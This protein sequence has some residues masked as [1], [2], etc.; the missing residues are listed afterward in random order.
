MPM[1]TESLIEIKDV[2]FNYGPQVILDHISLSV[3][4]GDFLGIIGPN[5]GGKSTLLK[6]ILGLLKPTSGQIC[7]FG[8]PLPD[9]HNWEKVGYVPQKASLSNTSFPVTVEEV[10]SM[11]N[12]NASSIADALKNTETYSLRQNLI[13]HLSGGQMQRVFIARALASRPQLLILDEPTVGV[14]M[15]SQEKFYSL[16]RDL[17]HK[18][19]LTLILVSHDVNVISEEVN[20][21]ACLN[22]E[23]ICHTTPHEFAKGDYLKKLY[24]KDL[25]LI[26]HTHSH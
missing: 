1:T 19:N 7:L 11:G 6:I 3:N 10:V 13:T 24:S 26:S 9:F 16:L 17:N 21:L 12:S 22:T 2:T 15:E 14:D 20:L 8:Q 4:R 23:L 18:H 25:Q 5:G